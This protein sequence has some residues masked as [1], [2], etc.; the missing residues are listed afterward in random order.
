MNR[1]IMENLRRRGMNDEE[2]NAGGDGTV[3]RNFY[4]SKDSTYIENQIINV[5]SGAN[6]YNGSRPTDKKQTQM[7]PVMA[8]EQVVETLIKEG[9]IVS[10][11][12]FSILY[13][14]DEEMCLLGALNM[15]GFANRV[16]ELGCVPEN[17]KPSIDSIKST[18]FG[19]KIY[20]DWDYTGLKTKVSHIRAVAKG[21]IREMSNRGYCHVSLSETT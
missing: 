16:C 10:K 17:L 2:Q 11:Q 5:Q 20:P 13:K 15:Q 21:Y 6:F 18:S 3:A 12:D 7:S 1:R 19:S 14:L 9:I 8:F 4:M